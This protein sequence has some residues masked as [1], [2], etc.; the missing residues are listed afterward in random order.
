V[1]KL[2]GL[3]AYLELIFMID[4]IVDSPN[5]PVG[6]LSVLFLFDDLSETYP[7]LDPFK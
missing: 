7:S 1:A 4:L 6:P 3:S 2:F 5:V